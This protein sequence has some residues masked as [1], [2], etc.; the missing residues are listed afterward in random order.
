MESS[1]YPSPFFIGLEGGATRSTLVVT[2]VLGR[3]LRR[4]EGGPCSMSLLTKINSS[5]L[6]ALLL[7]KSTA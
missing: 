3:V 2:D 5:A 1:S 4:A 6:C 7:L